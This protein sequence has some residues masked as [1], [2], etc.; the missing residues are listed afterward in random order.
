VL[1][2]ISFYLLLAIAFGITYG[3]RELSKKKIFPEYLSA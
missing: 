2:N 1:S 3:T